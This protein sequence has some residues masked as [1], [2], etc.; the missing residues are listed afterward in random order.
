MPVALFRELVGQS[1]EQM[2]R[3]LAD[4]RTRFEHRGDRGTAGAEEPFRDFLN[5][6]LPRDLNVG[7]GEI[8][9]TAEN[10]S[11]QTD[12]VIAAADH[13]FLFTPD[14][15]G[16]FLIEGIVAAGEVKSVLTSGELNSA[17]ENAV[18]FKRLRPAHLEGS[19]INA[20]P[21]DIDRFYDGRPHFLVAFESQLKLETV[22]EKVQE[23]EA[24]HGAPTFDGIFLLG[25]GW[26][27]NFGD[28]QGSFRFGQPGG[29][30]A[31]GWVSVEVEEV[32]FDLLVWLSAVI[33]R[34]VRF[35]P[36]TQLYL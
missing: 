30:P 5:E 13:P 11:G 27:I 22:L 8:I 29:E 10:R 26:L 24:E 19:L 23:F 25:R 3:R 18:R 7:Q 33:P 35:R 1:Q 4:A 20:N 9:D 14:S 32:L 28:G 34:I 36:I 15:P 21:S 2:H 16:L 31:T 12:V 17:L 6:Y